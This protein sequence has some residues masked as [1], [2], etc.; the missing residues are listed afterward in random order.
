M[1]YVINMCHF[2]IN[3]LVRFSGNLI[4]FGLPIEDDRLELLEQQIGF[5]L[6]TDFKFIIKKFN[7]ISLMGTSVLGIGHQFGGASLNAV[8]H[9]EHF[10]ASNKMPK[11]LLAFSPD[12]R[13]NH[14][15]LNLSKIRNGVCPVVFWQW[16]CNYTNEEEI[17]VCNGSF[18]DWIHEV[19]IGWTLE[20][21]NYD[22]SEK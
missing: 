17:E 10:E 3:E 16:D 20:E 21:Y 2:V 9:F 19:M 7:G 6:P 4:S 22:G 15:C 14:Y 12:G 8:Y 5:N 18:I 11:N 1:M 13:G